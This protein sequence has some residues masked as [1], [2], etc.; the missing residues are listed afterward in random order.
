M[1][2]DEKNVTIIDQ[3]G[4]T[5]FMDGNENISVTAPNE[6]VCSNSNFI[7]PSGV[8]VLTETIGNYKLYSLPR[9]FYNSYLISKF[10]E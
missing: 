2:D 7:L 10:F 8:F 1:N 3:S 9:I 4:N 6:S 5:Y